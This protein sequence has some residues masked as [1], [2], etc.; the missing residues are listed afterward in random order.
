MYYKLSANNFYFVFIS[1][2]AK[3]TSITQLQLKE[4]VVALIVLSTQ[5]ENLTSD[6]GKKTMKR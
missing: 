3:R 6:F 1:L 5:V 2:S 4:L